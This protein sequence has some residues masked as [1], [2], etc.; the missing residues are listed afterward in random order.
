[1]PRS[2]HGILEVAAKGWRWRLTL[3]PIN[4]I[5]LTQ[6]NKTRTSPFASLFPTVQFLE[7]DPVQ[8]KTKSP[9]PHR[10]PMLSGE[11]PF[12]SKKANKINETGRDYGL[13][14]SLLCSLPSFQSFCREARDRPGFMKA[15][16]HVRW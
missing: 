12:L 11:A 10:D 16:Y 14:G 8:V 9:T 1:M 15:F 2:L 5:S 3:Q 7:S 6:K 4:R 13:E